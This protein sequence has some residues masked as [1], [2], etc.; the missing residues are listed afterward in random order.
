MAQENTIPSVTEDST[1]KIISFN[2]K[3]D[4][5]LGRKKFRWNQRKEL[6]AQL[7]RMSGASI[8]GVQELTS[9]MRE[10]VEAL[11]QGEYSVMGF[12]RF[13]GIREDQDEHTDIIVKDQD[14]S[15]SYCKTFWLSKQPERYGSRAYY[16]F[17][18]R[19]C[20]VVEATIKAT[21]QRIR[22]FN[23]H[24]DHICGLARNLGVRIILEY[25]EKFNQA[26]PLP[27]ILMG[28][29]NAKFGSR[30]IQ[31]LRNN[32]HPHPHVHL[33]DVYKSFSPEQITNTL[34]FFSNKP[35]VGKSPI[36]YIFVSDEFEVVESH[37]FTKEINGGY[38]SDH[39][40]LIATLRLKI[41]PQPKISQNP[42]KIGA[43][44]LL[45][46]NI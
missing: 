31:I 26:D 9:Y 3:H 6:A 29:F 4:M 27:T 44:D 11:L 10:D 5:P 35:K 16:S 1:I 39:F 46:P 45:T 25:M 21:G 17:F 42:A 30:P 13:Y 7:I 43:P 8:I 14:V 37:I 18:P 19:I 32:L 20:T 28:D 23:T 40:P 38:P 34:H 36:D 12:G 33:T 22:V 15:V 2:L 41:P 24:F